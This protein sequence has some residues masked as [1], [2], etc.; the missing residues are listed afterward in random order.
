MAG[1]T[2]PTVDAGIR[3]NILNLGNY[4]WYDKNNNG[5]QDATEQGINALA[6]RLYKDVDADNIP[7]GAAIAT[8]T[9]NASGI[10]NFGSLNRVIT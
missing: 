8:T 5:T 3:T 9:T 2:L 10:Y 7:D 1:E 4:V 6:V